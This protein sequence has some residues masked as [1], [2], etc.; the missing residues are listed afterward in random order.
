MEKYISGVHRDREDVEV[1]PNGDRS[2][3][4]TVVIL[5]MDGLN[6]LRRERRSKSFGMQSAV[7]KQRTARCVIERRM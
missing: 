1:C 4:R 3:C 5:E 7:N 6:K 2:L